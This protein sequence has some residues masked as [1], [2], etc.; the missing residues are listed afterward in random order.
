M[1]AMAHPFGTDDLG[2]DVLS[3]ILFGARISLTVC[4]LSAAVALVIA[5]PLGLVAGYAGRTLDRIIGRLFDTIFAFPSSR[6]A[7]KSMSSPR[8]CSAPRHLASS[9]DISC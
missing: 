7:A 1:L 5:V 2:R 9:G 6:S 4:F 8:A 3:R